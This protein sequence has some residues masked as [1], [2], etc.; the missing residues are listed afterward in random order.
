V[1][2]RPRYTG[3]APA[4]CPR[5]THHSA[6]LAATSSIAR[7]S[8]SGAVAA[9]VPHIFGQVQQGHHAASPGMVM[10]ND[11]DMRWRRSMVLLVSMAG[12]GDGSMAA[13]GIYHGPNLG[14]DGPGRAMVIRTYC[15]SDLS[16]M[17]TRGDFWVW[18]AS[19]GH[20]A[21]QSRE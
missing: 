4:A 9:E 21:L 20:L 6:P 10:P 12:V 15:A 16:L 3:E 17:A 2:R 5:E 19:R 13:A 18:P 11:A 8:P 1:R 14:P 7:L